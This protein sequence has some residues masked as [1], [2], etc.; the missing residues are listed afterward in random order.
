MLTAL[1]LATTCVSSTPGGEV[2]AA[3]LERRLAERIDRCGGLHVLV[4]PAPR[5]RAALPVARRRRWRV[6]A[7]GR[8]SY[9]VRTVGASI[10]V[11][12]RDTRGLVYGVGWLLRHLDVVNGTPRLAAAANVTLSPRFDTRLTQIG[13]RPKNNSYDAWTLPMFERRIEDFALWGASGV[14][15][16]APVSDDDATGPLFPAPP[17]ET[18]AGIARITHRLGLDVALYYPELGDYTKPGQVAAEVRAFARVLADLPH[19]DALYVPG[20]DPGHTDP[21]HLFPLVARQAAV[22]HQRN[23]GAPVYLSTQGFD[24]AGLAAFYRQ[25]DRQPDWLAGVFVGPQTRDPL[26]VQRRRIPARYPLILYPDI[27]HTMHAQFP[28]PRWWPE[29]ALTEGRE[30]INP[31]PAAYTLIARRFLPLTQGFVTY[32]EGINDDFN[33]LLWFQLGWSLATDPQAMAR[34]YARMFIGDPAAAALPFA[35][36]G[37]WVGDPAKNAGIDRTLALTDRIRPA[38]FADWRLDSLRYRSV[39]DALVRHRSIAARQRIAAVQAAPA[40]ATARIA[41]DQPDGPAV[42]ALRAR[43]FALA[44]RLWRQARLQLSVQRYGA[45]TIERGA[46]LDRADIDLTGRRAILAQLAKGFPLPD[47]SRRAEGALYDDLGRPDAEPHLVRGAG[48]AADPQ[49][50]ETAIDGIAD[51]TAEDGWPLPALD[52]A[53]TLY[54]RPIRLRYT[55]LDPHRRYRLVATYAGEDYTLPMTLTAN[56]RFTLQSAFNRTSNPMTVEVA[57]PPAATAGGT[58]DLAWTRPPG[59]GGSG[60]GHQVAETWLI[61]DPLPSPSH[62]GAPR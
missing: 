50:Y 43:L 35:L 2:A 18:L 7:L 41:L 55:G 32:S 16:I 29:F 14:Q 5:V 53:E 48:F 42:A 25:L 38:R 17:R 44:E 56:G 34:Q 51:R 10:V 11:T 6:P 40:A 62:A 59:L 12:A 1:A 27:A 22:L 47:R 54:D 4:A 19:V 36:E 13:Y 49:M 23:P 37:N 60:R 46:N 8:E 15:I 57:I 61:P 28:V 58:L 3:L 31:R 21:D 9:A 52:Y 33:Q 39:Y 20:G 30:P 26:P 24:A 45:T